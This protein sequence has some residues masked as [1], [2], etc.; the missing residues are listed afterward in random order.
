MDSGMFVWTMPVV[1]CVRFNMPFGRYLM[2]RL[3]FQL[4]SSPGSFWEMKYRNFS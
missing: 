4:A 1:N 3:P 2:K